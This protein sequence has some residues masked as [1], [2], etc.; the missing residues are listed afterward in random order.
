MFHIPPIIIFYGVAQ[1]LHIMCTYYDHT[2]F[3]AHS[4]Y[5]AEEHN[6]HRAHQEGSNRRISELEGKIEKLVE[7]LENNSKKQIESQVGREVG[8]LVE[9]ETEK[10]IDKVL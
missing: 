4:Q 6:K 10:L 2:K 1:I 8:A 5:N 3:L 7:K 9:K